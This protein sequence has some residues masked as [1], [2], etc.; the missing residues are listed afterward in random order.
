MIF[1]CFVMQKKH[2]KSR[3]S[4]RAAASAMV[5][6]AQELLTPTP[7]PPPADEHQVAPCT[8]QPA[9]E[10]QVA[11][12]TPQPTGPL[13]YDQSV[14][15]AVGGINLEVYATVFI[16]VVMNYLKGLLHQYGRGGG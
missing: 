5:N 8:P 11:P 10:H 15:V 14:L 12:C 9:D 1:G 16:C 6:E 4:K 2:S 13:R 7:I 3:S